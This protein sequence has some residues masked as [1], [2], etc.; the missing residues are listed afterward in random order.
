MIR[1]HKS[2][3]SCPNCGKEYKT[4]GNQLKHT[5][6]CELSKDRKEEEEMEIPT[7]E[8]MYKIIVTMSEK[9]KRME[10]K[11]NELEMDKEKNKNQIKSEKI[12]IEDV[13]KRKESE[14]IENIEIK[15]HLPKIEKILEKSFNEI[16][17]K[18]I[19]RINGAEE[20]WYYNKEICKNVYVK[21]ENTWKILENEKMKKIISK[22][23]TEIL[24][25]V[26]EWYSS[27]ERKWTD[28]IFD[29]H[30]KLLMMYMSIEYDNKSY[31]T[32]MINSIKKINFN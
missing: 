19:E 16:L 25:R 17:E 10:K 22:I 1:L 3:Y 32:K 8:D 20:V 7:R 14:N 13:L 24:K 9:I 31:T 11:I 5:L 2:K 28:E 30:N 4:R 18:M 21:T 29:K 26:E 15:K 23:H 6:I 12:K 27:H